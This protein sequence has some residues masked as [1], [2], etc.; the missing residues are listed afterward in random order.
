MMIIIWILKK[1]IIKNIF[2]KEKSIKLEKSK[3]GE[4]E[5]V[6]VI[7]Q[8][9][10]EDNMKVE[11]CPDDMAWFD[12]GTHDHLLEAGN[13]VKAIQNRTSRI[14]GKVWKSKVKIYALQVV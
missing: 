11:Y 14:V 9:I 12:C 7:N 4:L 10:E 3:R 8:Y 6:D 13:Y 5:I 2:V 1:H